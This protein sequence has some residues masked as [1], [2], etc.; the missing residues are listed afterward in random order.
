MILKVTMRTDS[1]ER[2]STYAQ[3]GNGKVGQQRDRVSRDE[4]TPNKQPLP[5]CPNFAPSFAPLFARVFHPSTQSTV[6]NWEPGPEIRRAGTAASS[7]THHD[8]PSGT[9]AF[10]QY[11]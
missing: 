8:G 3:E 11:V 9:A 4:K 1:N 2:E 7:M 5:F 10:I 6:E